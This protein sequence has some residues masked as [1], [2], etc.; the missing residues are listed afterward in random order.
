MLNC[1]EAIW[2][3][4]MP[5]PDTEPALVE[6][7]TVHRNPENDRAALRLPIKYQDYPTHKKLPNL[8]SSITAMAKLLYCAIFVALTTL[9]ACSGP[10]TSSSP[11]TQA[12][13]PT[14]ASIPAPT[15]AQAE[16]P[17]PAEVPTEVPAPTDTPIPT[18]MPAPTDTPPETTPESRTARPHRD[19]RY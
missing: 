9:L 18:A 19:E 12:Q 8:R 11:T 17:V 14:A 5:A 3:R 2:D 1:L 16:A 15:L 6:G 10:E 7:R 4:L 13:A